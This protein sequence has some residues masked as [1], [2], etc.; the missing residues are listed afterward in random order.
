VSVTG[1]GSLLRL[2]VPDLDVVRGSRKDARSGGVE[3]NVSRLATV[4]A[5]GPHRLKVGEVLVVSGPGVNEE[6]LVNTGDGELAV[7]AD[8]GDEGVVEGRPVGV[9]DGGGVGAAEGEEVGKLWRASVSE[10]EL[11][12]EEM[13]EKKKKRT[14]PV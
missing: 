8:G 5:R 10:G 6:L 7:L 3:T 12:K 14:L 1:K 9:E 4:S 11:K 13:A 2:D